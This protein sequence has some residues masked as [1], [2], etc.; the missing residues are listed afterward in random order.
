ML[1]VWR[2]E[3]GARRLLVGAWSAEVGILGHFC[4]ARGG[5]SSTLGSFCSAFRALSSAFESFCSALRALSSTFESFC[6]AFRALSS[7]N[8][9]LSSMNGPLRV[10]YVTLLAGRPALPL[11]RPSRGRVHCCSARSHAWPTCARP[12]SDRPATRPAHP[13]WKARWRW[14]LPTRSNG[15]AASCWRLRRSGILVDLP[16]RGQRFLRPPN[17]LAKNSS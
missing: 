15:C 11:P 4:S 7:A 10:G 1:G 13:P 16:A 8:G 5:Q 17:A 2:S 14:A 12:A 3:L 9:A 6:S